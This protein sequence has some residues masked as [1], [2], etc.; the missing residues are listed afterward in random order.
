MVPYVFLEWCLIIQRDNCTLLSFG[1]LRLQEGV[2]INCKLITPCFRKQSSGK[3][4]QCIQ[5]PPT[6]LN[7][8]VVKQNASFRKNSEKKGWKSVRLVY[9]IMIYIAIKHYNYCMYSFGYF[10]GGRLWFA[11]VSEPS[12]SSIF[13][14]WLKSTQD[15]TDRGFRNVGKSQSDAGEIPERIHTISKTRRKFEIKDYNYCIL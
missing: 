2:S 6:L 15:G 8:S 4:I 7:L 12:V 13:K 5:L 11:D 10:P 1:Y 14:G 9:H 3:P